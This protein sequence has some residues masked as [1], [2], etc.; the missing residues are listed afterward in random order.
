M[1]LYRLAPEAS[2]LVTD[3]LAR[4]VVGRHPAEAIERYLDEVSTTIDLTELDEAIDDVIASTRA[5][6]P[7]I[8]QRAAASVH[9]AL[10]LSRR[11]AG[12]PGVWR[13]LAVV[14]RP[15]FVRHRWA[16]EKWTTTR[17]RYWSPGMRHDNNVFSRLW[18]IAE[19][20]RDGDDYTLT[21]RAF[22]RQ[23]IAIQVFIRR[24]AWH[25]PAVVALLEELDGAPPRVIEHVTR[26]LVGALGTMV[27][28]AMSEG[29]LRRLVGELRASSHRKAP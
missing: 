1:K 26:D 18:W 27:L 19:L 3:E 16:Y 29:E 9:R 17:S 12:Q 5:H 8:E 7:V 13:F 14:H 4:G 21:E 2:H 11:E 22:S 28:E 6:D 23:T 10:P 25:R 24:Y 15:D 20:T